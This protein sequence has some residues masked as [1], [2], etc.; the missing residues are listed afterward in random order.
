RALQAKR[1]PV[2]AGLG[3][4]ERQELEEDSIAARGPAPLRIVVCRHERAALR[5]RTPN[6]HGHG[7]HDPGP[8]AGSTAERPRCTHS[9]ATATMRAKTAPIPPPVV[10]RRSRASTRC[11]R[12]NPSAWQAA[13]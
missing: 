1:Q 11:P 9:M 6:A 10:I 5:P 13:V 4:L 2:Q 12:T 8:A 7:L 3:A